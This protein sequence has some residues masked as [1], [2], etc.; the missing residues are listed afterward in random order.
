MDVICCGMYRA[1]ST[2]QYEVVAHLIEWRRRGERLGYREGSG[3]DPAPGRGR[4]RVLKCH[5]QHPNFARAVAEGDALAVYSYRDLRDV[6]DS[7]R[8]KAG[9]S[10]DELMAEGLVHRI[11]ENDRFWMARPG[12]L[13]QRYEDLVADPVAGVLELGRFL[14]IDLSVAEA[15]EVAEAYSPEANRRR[16]EAVRLASAGRDDSPADPSRATRLDP[17]T[18]LHGNHLRSGRVGGWR[19]AL[20]PGE[21][22]LLGLLGGDWLVRRGYEADRSWA[23]PSSS[24][25]R[26]ALALA[27]SR[28]HCWVYFTARR[29]PR[30]ARAS[31]RVLRLDRPLAESSGSGPRR[32]RQGVPST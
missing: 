12:V 6:V 13:A 23:P 8:H 4:F 31:R 9:R 2:W 24:P 29:F 3:Y 18:L 22:A 16:A 30:L 27:R 10:F 28:W 26:D 17:E 20:S 5:D 14:G 15:E 7:M 1:C 11:L 21:L 19:E 25:L 32:P